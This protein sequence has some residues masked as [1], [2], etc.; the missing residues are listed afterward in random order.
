MTV[1]DEQESDLATAVNPAAMLSE[2]AIDD[3]LYITA[4][5]GGPCSYE[6]CRCSGFIA[7]DY[8]GYCA[9]CSHPANAHW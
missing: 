1:H 8:A 7:D 5:V 3:P 6:N 9:N 2:P 4:I